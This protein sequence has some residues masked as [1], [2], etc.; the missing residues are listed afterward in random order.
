VKERK[1][2]MHVCEAMKAV[3]IACAYRREGD[4]KSSLKGAVPRSVM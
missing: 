2:A 1:A 4:I 3:A